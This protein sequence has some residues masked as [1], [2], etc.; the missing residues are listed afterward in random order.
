MASSF[1]VSASRQ[2]FLRWFGGQSPLEKIIKDVSRD[3]H[4]GSRDRR[5]VKE[6][7]YQIVRFRSDLVWTLNQ[8]ENPQILRNFDEALGRHWTHSQDSKDLNYG[9]ES[10]ERLKP[11]FK[12]NP[13][14][15]LTKAHGLEPN[16]VQFFINGTQSLEVLHDRIHRQNFGAPTTV[17]V[18][19]RLPDKKRKEIQNSL[20]GLGF[21]SSFFLKDSFS[22]FEKINLKEFKAGTLDKDFFIQDESSQLA[23]VSVTPKGHLLDFCAGAGGKALQIADQNPNLVIDAWEVNPG[24]RKILLERVRR[25]GLGGQIRVLNSLS[26]ARKVYDEVWVDSPCSGW[27]T[28]RRQPDL[29]LRTRLESLEKLIR[30][31]REIILSAR[32]FLGPGGILTYATCS[33]L[34]SENEENMGFVLEAF[35]GLFEK[36]DLSESIRRS[37]KGFQNSEAHDKFLT[38]FCGHVGR[39]NQ[40]G[41][42]VF[43]NKSRDSQASGGWIGDGFFVSKVK[44]VR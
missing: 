34:S 15:H 9:Y 13:G 27:G 10:H 38:E 11:E 32:K 37:P 24:R 39:N 25:S 41:L 43:P 36:V 26:D 35:S 28:L 14:D 20:L 18:S 2:I 4:L 17:R 16:L 40:I 1:V 30:L 23:A 44:L 5:L 31:Q 12:T 29:L 7:C 3:L 22:T 6:F 33:I 19:T 21:N 8:K 42:Y